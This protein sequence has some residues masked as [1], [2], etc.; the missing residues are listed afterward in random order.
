MFLIKLTVV[1]VD[2]RAKAV[3]ISTEC[4]V[5]VPQE[6]VTT[7]EKRFRLICMGINRWLAIEHNDTVSEISSHDEIVLDNEGGLLRIHNESFNNSRSRNSLCKVFVSTY[8][9]DESKKKKEGHNTHVL[10]QGTPRAHRLDKCPLED[11]EQGQW[12]H[13]AIHRQTSFELLDR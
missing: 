13:V 1:L 6:S 7:G 10:R 3:G 9:V 8:F 4:N 5:Q 12:Q 11:R 2:S